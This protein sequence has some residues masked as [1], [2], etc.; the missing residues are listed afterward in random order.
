MLLPGENTDNTIY[1]VTALSSTMSTYEDA[2]YL[3]YRK[4][5][6]KDT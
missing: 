3:L 2:T 6:A 1:V 5:M 4:N